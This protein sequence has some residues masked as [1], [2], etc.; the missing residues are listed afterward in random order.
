MVWGIEQSDEEGYMDR[1]KQV[2][3]EGGS[4]ESAGQQEHR[5]H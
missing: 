4:P 2:G 5:S 1:K 3:Q